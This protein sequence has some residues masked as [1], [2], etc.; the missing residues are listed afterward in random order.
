M[1]VV[2]HFYF[3]AGFFILLM[4]PLAH[5]QAAQ[6]EEPQMVIESTSNKLKEK[7]K[8]ENFKKDFRKINAFVEATIT[9]HVDFNRI[10]ALVLGKLWRKASAE[11]RA[12]F[13]S[14]FRVMLIRTYSRAFV[15]FKD[16]SVRFLPLMVK[17]V[18]K[19]VIVKTEILQPG[20]Q[21]IGVNYRMYE[22]NGVWKTYDIIIEGV[23]L[24]T[25]Y[26]TSFKNEVKRAG[27]LQAVIDQLAKRNTEALAVNE[28]S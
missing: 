5:L 13:S 17:D 28:N 14:E 19:K 8:D 10:S 3:N 22:K 21:P 4:A 2:K 16:W 6:L 23:S 1:N 25:N 7:L 24:V 26:R 27:S 18:N 9:P 11:E 20:I 12:G 15:E